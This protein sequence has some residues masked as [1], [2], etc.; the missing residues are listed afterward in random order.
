MIKELFLKYFTKY[1]NLPPKEKALCDMAGIFVLIGAV[2][3]FVGLVSYLGFWFEAFV[4]S[5]VYLSWSIV[6]MLYQS[7]V[8]WYELEEKYKNDN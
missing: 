8:K 1:Y 5:M 4:L 2:F 7:R 3:G 6:K